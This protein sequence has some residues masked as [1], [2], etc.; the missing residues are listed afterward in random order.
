MYIYIY[1]YI[2]IKPSPV[3]SATLSLP[4]FD[5]NWHETNAFIPEKLCAALVT[6][7]ERAIKAHA[8]KEV[9]SRE[10]QIHEW[11]RLKGSESL[12]LRKWRAKK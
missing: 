6:T 7:L 3:V 11:K 4:L 12:S 9:A 8:K 2:Y 5:N 10:G 1:I